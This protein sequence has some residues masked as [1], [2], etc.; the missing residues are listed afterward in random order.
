MYAAW[1][2]FVLFACASAEAW[3]RRI[4]RQEIEAKG[5]ISPE[6]AAPPS[7]PLDGPAPKSFLNVI[8]TNLLTLTARTGG[9][10]VPIEMPVAGEIVGIQM[11]L[12]GADGGAI[13]RPYAAVTTVAKTATELQNASGN[14]YLAFLHY[15]FWFDSAAG[16]TL[17][18][19]NQ[20]F[21]IQGFAVEAHRQ[22]FLCINNSSEAVAT[23]YLLQK[24]ELPRGRVLKIRRTIRK[25]K[26]PVACIPICKR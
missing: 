23:V 6:N 20:Y 22:L 18:A 26:A 1:A 14:D 8:Y 25:K 11:M 24:W 15:S 4:F 12:T 16:R 2:I 9:S 13:Q 3:F 21:P 7:I 17:G 5:E 10:T 19:I